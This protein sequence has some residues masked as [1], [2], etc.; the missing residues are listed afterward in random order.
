V[1]RIGVS[2]KARFAVG[3]RFPREPLRGGLNGMTW[4]LC[5][6]GS[7][8]QICPA[9]QSIGMR[10]EW[11]A[12]SQPFALLILF[13]IAYHAA[14]LLPHLSDS[15]SRLPPM[16]MFLRVIRQ[17]VAVI[18]GLRFG[19]LRSARAGEL[20]L[21]YG[22]LQWWSRSGIN[23]CEI[24]GVVRF[25]TFATW[26]NSG[27]EPDRGK[28]ISSPGTYEASLMWPRNDGERQWN[29]MSDWTCH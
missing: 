7:G 11:R 4:P 19:R 1:F 3:L 17:T 9:I 10:P 22:V 21:N 8:A 23:V 18:L 2:A 12:E 27:I 6:M 26:G 29:T 28:G 16:K 24:F 25:S 20:E 14:G 5:S 15:N 13:D